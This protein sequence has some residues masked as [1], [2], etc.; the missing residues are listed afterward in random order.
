MACGL[1]IGH[2]ATV[3]LSGGGTVLDSLPEIVIPL[4]PGTPAR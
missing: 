2:S 3:P 1:G 4:L